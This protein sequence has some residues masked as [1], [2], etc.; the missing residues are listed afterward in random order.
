M[1]SISLRKYSTI[2]ASLFVLFLLSFLLIHYYPVDD[3]NNVRQ[4]WVQGAQLIALIGSIVGF[5]LFRKWGGLSSVFGRSI[6]FF[7]LG[8][9]AQFFGGTVFTYYTAIQGIELP[10]P[11]IADIGYFISMLSYIIAAYYVARV[12]GFRSVTQK[13]K[14]KLLAIIVPL[15]LLSLSY[16]IFLRGYEFD[17]TSPLIIFLDFAYPLGDAIYISLGILALISGSI[18]LGGIMKIPLSFLLLALLLQFISDFNFLYQAYNETWVVGGYGDFIY[19]TAYCVMFL[20]L[21]AIK[22]AFKNISNYSK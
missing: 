1:Y 15:L 17:W 22:S 20:S 7:S 6:F 11:S 14:G 4:L 13:I 3:T 18:Y 12:V 8:L 9:F 19:M 16:T 2:P 21:L 5:N 10:Y